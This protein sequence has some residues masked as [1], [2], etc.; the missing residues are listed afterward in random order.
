MFQRN[1]VTCSY[2]RGN[3]L[4]VQPIRRLTSHIFPRLSPVTRFPELKTTYM[5]SRAKHRLHIFPRLASAEIFPAFGTDYMP[6]GA[7]YRRIF[8]Q[9]WQ[10][11]RFSRFW[12][13]LNDLYT[14]RRLH[15][16]Q[17]LASGRLNLCLPRLNVFRLATSPPQVGQV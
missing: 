8:S 6:P 13:R 14:S 2:N 5:F 11:F 1:S 12:Q 3:T 7:R 9:I 15:V 16:F 17:L 4:I 10:R